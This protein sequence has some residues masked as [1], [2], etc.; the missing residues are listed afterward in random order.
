MMGFSTAITN[1]DYYLIY[2]SDLDYLRSDAAMLNLER[3]RTHLQC[4]P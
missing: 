1:S 4:Q 2:K 3:A